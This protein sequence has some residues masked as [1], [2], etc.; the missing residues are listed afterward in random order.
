MKFNYRNERKYLT[1]LQY[2]L[3]DDDSDDLPP[4]SPRSQPWSTLH[5]Y[6]RILGASGL[7]IILVKKLLFTWPNSPENWEY[8]KDHHGTQNPIALLHA[9]DR[10]SELNTTVLRK[11]DGIMERGMIHALLW[12]MNSAVSC[13]V[14]VD[15]KWP[16]EDMKQFFRAWNRNWIWLKSGWTKSCLYPS[17]IHQYDLCVAVLALMLSYV[18]MINWIFYSI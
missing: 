17:M 3:A 4:I 13:R 5:R 16:E 10:I 2:K 15:C 9:I 8:Y 12:P 18:E 14:P 7:T 6:P 11:G 1:I